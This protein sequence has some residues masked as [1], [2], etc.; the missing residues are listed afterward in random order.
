M[1]GGRGGV[2]ELV[3]VVMVMMVVIMMMMVVVVES[4][5]K[6]DRAYGSY[7]RSRKAEYRGKIAEK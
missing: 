7:M 6:V 4:I 3:M 2:V 1:E 5:T